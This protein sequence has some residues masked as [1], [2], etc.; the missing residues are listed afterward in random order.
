MPI[1]LVSPLDI[2]KDHLVKVACIFVETVFHSCRISG[3]HYESMTM[4]IYYSF[5]LYQLHLVFLSMVS[6][7]MPL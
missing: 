5:N 2:Y 4:K 6:L 1:L 7:C 3:E